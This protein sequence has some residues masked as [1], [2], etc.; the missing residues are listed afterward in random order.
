[1][2][3]QYRFY[4]HLPSFDY[5][6]QLLRDAIWFR[7]NRR[8][9]L[10]SIAVSSRLSRTAVVDLVRQANADVVL[11]YVAVNPEKLPELRSYTMSSRVRPKSCPT[12]RLPSLPMCVGRRKAPHGCL[13]PPD[14]TK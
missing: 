6:T 5:L 13:G 4:L 9:T 3:S 10:S 11:C 1:M 2:F 12:E 7:Y 8:R 14:L